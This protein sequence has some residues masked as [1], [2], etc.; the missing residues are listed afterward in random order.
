MDFRLNKEQQ[1]IIK[2]A[3]EFAQ[4]EFPDV[5]RS[6]T[7]RRPLISVSGKR[8]AIWGLWGY[9]STRPTAGQATAFLS[10]A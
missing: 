2:A 5:A 6:S 4:K 8:P 3:R 1:D 10:T 7:G 9:S